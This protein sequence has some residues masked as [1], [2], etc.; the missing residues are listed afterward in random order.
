V[1]L[2]IAK[3]LLKDFKTLKNYYVSYM[4]VLLYLTC[5]FCIMIQQVHAQSKRAGV[6]Y[7]S[8]GIG[9]DFNCSPPCTNQSG[10]MSTANSSATI[11]DKNGVLQFYTDNETIWNRNHQIIANGTDLYSC[12]WAQ[13]GSVIVPLTSNS[14]Q[15]YLVTCDIIRYPVSSNV[16]FTCQDINPARNILSLSLIDMSSK[17]G[18]GNVLWENKVI[19][20]SGYVIGTIAAIKHANTKDTWLMT[21]DFNINRFVSLLLTDC[22]IQDT[23]VSPDLN[24]LVGEW[25]NPITFSPKG[26]LFHIRTAYML[27]ESGSM[28]AYFDNNTGLASD[29][30]FF[31]G[32]NTQACFSVDN[33]YLYKS[34]NMARYDL[35]DLTDTAV[36]YASRENLDFGYGAN[37]GA[38]NGPDGKVYF[39]GNRPYRFDLNGIDQPEAATSTYSKIIVDITKPMEYG[40]VNAAPPNFVQSWFDPDF[41]EYEY[42][43]PVIHYTRTCIT[44]PATL[45]ATDIPPATP[46]HWEIEEADVPLAI[47]YNADTITHMFKKAGTHT[48]R[49]VIDFICIPDIITCNDIVVDAL[50]QKDYMKNV[51]VCTGNEYV[52]NAEP[53]Q[54]HY[55]WN[56]GNTGQQQTGIAGNTYSVKVSNT[57]GQA[58]DSVYLKKISYKLPNLITPNNDGYNDTF[59]IESDEVFTGN[60][61]IYNSWGATIYQ[62]NNYKNTWPEGIIDAGIYYYRFT[63]STC[64]PVNSWLQVIK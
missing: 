17:N 54:I 15:Y 11:C 42:G 39:I 53:G 48:A 36:I 27:P 21:Y 56:T 8:N 57:C 12:R 31:R 51:D 6:W 5:I 1:Y 43:S 60:L 40:Q 47:Y 52:L 4:H 20:G 44:G 41:K 14:F 50:P 58:E 9:Y 61:E 34:G 49:L 24:V 62:N 25:N 19:Y 7:V 33:H 46:Y 28:I 16:P 37:F 32:E 29:P 64:E 35:S 23:I 18:S 38:Q 59:E 3:N 22:G 2:T 45:T 63:Y 30:V 13:Q 55:L 10:A 26:N